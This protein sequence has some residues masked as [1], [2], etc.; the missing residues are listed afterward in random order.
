V[1]VVCVS[2]QIQTGMAVPAGSTTITPN[3]VASLIA[4]NTA[5]SISTGSSVPGLAGQRPTV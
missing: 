5:G 2:E 3:V 1:L 4:S